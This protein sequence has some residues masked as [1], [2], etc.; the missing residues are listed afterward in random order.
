MLILLRHIKI[1]LGLRLKGRL[2]FEIVIHLIHVH[3]LKHA[4]LLLILKLVETHLLLLLIILLLVLLLIAT[5]HASSIL[6]HIIL[7]LHLESI[8]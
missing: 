6:L 7:S 8:K 2:S 5:H 4:L 1:R 3:A